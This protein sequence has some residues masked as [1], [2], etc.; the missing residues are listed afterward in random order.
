MEIRL[1]DNLMDEKLREEYTGLV[2]LNSELVRKDS[3]EYI[4]SLEMEI[5][6][7]KSQLANARTTIISLR[8]QMPE[9]R[10]ISRYPEDEADDYVE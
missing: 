4:H 9:N 10:P 2:I 7:L 3:P 5:R 8:K 6:E 1:R